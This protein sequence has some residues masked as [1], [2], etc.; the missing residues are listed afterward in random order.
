[1]LTTKKIIIPLYE[2]KLTI[3]IFDNWSEVKSALPEDEQDSESRG[4]TWT[5]NNNN[6]SFAIGTAIHSKHKLF[7]VHEAEHIKNLIWLQIGY[8]PDP[9]N[10]EVDAYLIK[11]IY[12]NIMDA[13]ISHI[14]KK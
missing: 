1:M 14:E 2:I 8:R 13:I 9:N 12:S 5:G 3:F 11:Y 7:A 10:D 4:V 6:G